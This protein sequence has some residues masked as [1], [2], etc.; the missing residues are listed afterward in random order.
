[1]S[2]CSRPPRPTQTPTNKDGPSRRRKS[3]YPP[4]AARPRQPGT[5]TARLN[6]HPTIK[7][8]LMQMGLLGSSSSTR[9]TIDEGNGFGITS[10][11][12]S[13]R[14]L[15]FTT[16]G[17]STAK[18]HKG[19]CFPPQPLAQNP[20]VVGGNFV[21]APTGA[22]TPSPSH[23]SPGLPHGGDRLALGE[24]LWA[25]VVVESRSLVHAPSPQSTT[26]PP[27]LRP[28]FQPSGMQPFNGQ[29]T[30][31]VATACAAPSTA[32]EGRSSQLARMA[33][34][35][36]CTI[37]ASCSDVMALASWPSGQSPGC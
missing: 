1:M 7:R 15:E 18:G 6:L 33:E 4:R 16:G 30:R 27:P 31:G 8:P 21:A 25:G 22:T 23:C 13:N 28:R 24:V 20:V 9:I 29:T 19:A 10:P 14:E 3:D 34:A 26:L 12:D 32:S 5:W 17:D 2:L 36:R 11:G 35:P 37:P